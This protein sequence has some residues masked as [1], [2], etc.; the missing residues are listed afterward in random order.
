MLRARASHSFGVASTEVATAVV[1]NGA[2][3]GVA[4]GA[5]RPRTTATALFPSGSS[6]VLF[7][8]G[9]GG[10]RDIEGK[11]ATGSG[12][13]AGTRASFKSVPQKRIRSFSVTSA[14]KFRI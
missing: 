1:H 10:T 2:E 8:N 14:R 7:A 12:E 3:C 6:S 9:A 11:A 5:V 4:H 13:Q